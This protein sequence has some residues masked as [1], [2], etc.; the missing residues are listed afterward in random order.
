[1][2]AM[3]VARATVCSHTDKPDLTMIPVEVALGHLFLLVVVNKL[4]LVTALAQPAQPMDAYRRLRRCK[5]VQN[6]IL[7]RKNTRNMI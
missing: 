3:P 1:M 6:G 2:V 4:A 7:S 5:K